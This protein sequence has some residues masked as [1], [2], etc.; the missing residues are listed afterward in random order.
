MTYLKRSELIPKEL[1]TATKD[2][3]QRKFLKL[4][5]EKQASVSKTPHVDQ[6]QRVDKNKW[7]I[8]LSSPG[9]LNEQ[10]CKNALFYSI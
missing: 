9:A 5:E 7:V 2:Q 10:F 6:T 3:Q 8:N 4:V 1:F